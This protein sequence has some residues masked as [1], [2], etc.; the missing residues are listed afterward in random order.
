MVSAPP[1]I[2]AFTDYRQFLKD[3]LS[4]KQKSSQ[5]SL[6][7]F[8]KRAGFKSHNILQMVIRGDRGISLRSVPKYVKA[9]G[10]SRDEG[11]YFEQLVLLDSTARSKQVLRQVEAR[12]KA[13]NGR[14]PVHKRQLALFRQ[15]LTPIICEMT[16]LREFQE[17]PNWISNRLGRRISPDEVASLLSQLETSGLLQRRNGRLR[18]GD[19]SLDTGDGIANTDLFAYHETALSKA[20]DALWEVAPERRSFQVITMAL[21]TPA[22]QELTKLIENFEAEVF[23]LAALPGPKTDVFQVGLQAFPVLTDTRPGRTKP[24]DAK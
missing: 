12:Q 15:W 6:R 14:S 20:D 24:K 13:T 19:K 4:H 11:E 3:W 23:R 10:L 7:G 2:F 8:S 9:L 5:F 21:S 1:N 17:D 22:S 18:P 16:R